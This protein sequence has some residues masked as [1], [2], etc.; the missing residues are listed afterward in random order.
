MVDFVSRDGDMVDAICAQ[1]LPAADEAEA[2]A[3]VYRNNPHLSK[4]PV[5]LPAG[6]QM[7]LPEVIETLPNEPLR[8][9]S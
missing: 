6:V 8:I 7:Q 1:L 4:F 9:W 3:A 2:C 5:V